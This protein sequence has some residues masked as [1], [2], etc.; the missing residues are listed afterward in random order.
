M[1]PQKWVEGRGIDRQR[2]DV[3][4]RAFLVGRSPAIEEKP[5]SLLSNKVPNGD[6]RKR[7][8]EDHAIDGIEGRRDPPEHDGQRRVEKGAL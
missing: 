3:C 1:P 8:P 2:V 7:S 5:P 4:V 6:V